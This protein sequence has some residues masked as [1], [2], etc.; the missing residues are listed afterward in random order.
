MRNLIN[1]GRAIFGIGII[2]LGLISIISKDFIIGRPPA[3]PDTVAVNPF[4]AYLSGTF[5]IIAGILIILKTKGG[6]SSLLIA[7]FIVFLTISRHLMSLMADWLNGFKALALLGGAL[8]IA[9]TFYE[10]GP[11]TSPTFMTNAG[12]RKKI[13]LFGTFLLAAFFV[14]SGYAHFKFAD[15]IIDGLIPA[16]IPFHT[17]FTYFC[18]ICLLA[19]GIGL[20]I[21][22]VR[23]LAALLSGIMVLGWFFL[24]HLPRFFTNMS[25][26]SD[27]M[28]VWESFAF[29]GI[30]FV[31]AGVFSKK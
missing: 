27:R 7:L 6:L 28:G 12:T 3:W 26:A 18:G 8:I 31:L 5:S 25:D 23:R 29:S 20:L 21:P 1:L 9:S 30:F 24:L 22:P 15:F 10:E 11:E 19:G 16:Y 2:A 17:F 4:L 13:T 14:A